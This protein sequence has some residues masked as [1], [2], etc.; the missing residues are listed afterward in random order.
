MMHIN[1]IDITKRCGYKETDSLSDFLKEV[2]DD[3]IHE[4]FKNCID[5]C[6]DKNEHFR[7]VGEECKIKYTPY[8]NSKISE[9]PEEI[10]LSYYEY[11]VTDGEKYYFYHPC[12]R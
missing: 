8:L 9:I 6:N 12:C 4:A 10:L 5:W 11:F 7:K 2:T 3:M 1:E